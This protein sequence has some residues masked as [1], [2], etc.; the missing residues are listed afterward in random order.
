MSYHR[1][2]ALYIQ[3]C[4]DFDSCNR[5]KITDNLSDRKKSVKDVDLQARICPIIEG[6]PLTSSDAAISIAAIVGKLQTIFLTG[7]SL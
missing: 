3:R 6:E 5:W 2:R 4:G 1:A 7:K